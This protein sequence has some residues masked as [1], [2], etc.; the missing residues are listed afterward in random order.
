VPI[1]FVLFASLFCEN[2]SF[3]LGADL[4]PLSS[5]S[6]LSAPRN[7]HW[8]FRTIQKPPLPSVSNRSWPKSPLDHFV[9]AN[10]EAKGIPPAEPAEKVRW[11]RRV[12]FD[13]VGL[14]PTPSD[15]DDFLRNSDGNAY[16]R[17]ID[18]LLS[19]PQYGERWGR[20]WL[21]L[22]RFAES[23]GF[24]H[25]AVR[26]HAWRY[27]DYV[28]RS[29]NADKPYDTFV[30]EQIAGDTFDQGDRDALIA[31][32]FNLLG[33]DMVDSADQVQRRHNSL[34]DMTDTTGLVFLGLTVGCA[35]C[36]DHKF[37]PISQKDYY[38]LQA[39]FTPSVF[40]RD[41]PIPTEQEQAV[42]ETAMKRHGMR[43]HEMRAKIEVLEKPY[44]EQVL[45]E[46]L[47]VLS[48]ETR[49]AHSAAKDKRTAEQI[50]LVKQT[51][52]NVA[53]SEKEL[54]DRMP[55][56]D[57]SARKALLDS[58]KRLPKPYPVPMTLALKHGGGVGEKTYV[59]S[60]GDYANPT[61]EVASDFPSVLKSAHSRLGSI[62]GSGA[63]AE[64]NDRAALAEWIASDD[65]PLTARVM[66]N[67]IWQH[68][69]G[70]GLVPSSSDFG[71]NGQPPTHPK[72]LDWLAGQFIASGWSIKSMHKMILLSATY[73][74]S[75]KASLAALAG[76]P[77]NRLY[78]RFPRLRLEGEVIRDSLLAISGRLNQEME[79]PG[80]YPPISE[81][82]FKGAKGWQASLDPEDH[83]RRSI[84]IFARRNL[85][86]PFLEVFDA[87]DNNV[88]CAAREHSTS[89]PQSL[90]L[91]NSDEAM[92]A[93]TT[94]AENLSKTT[95]SIDDQIKQAFR[96]ILT[97]L[98][99]AQEMEMSREFMKGSPLRE[100]CRALFNSNAFVYVD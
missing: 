55:K 51:A 89:A 81:H 21:D 43:E 53:I 63:A 97:R 98:P 49:A 10:L 70:R 9:L 64:R 80:V 8:A 95:N 31:T 19:S 12:T 96:L 14:P 56:E 86:F 54:L 92:A 69:F 77:E 24:E 38:S 57:Q 28:V 67:R 16:E 66:V 94:L 32:A 4:S 7:E 22:V 84:Y 35:R 44:R 50:A 87:P 71:T 59:L 83:A 15:L 45:A 42:Y 91:L 20:H 90:T 1:V 75:S 46:K 25:D 74:Q 39:F 18:R 73:R 88:S 29:L 93:A 40:H 100:L 65:N 5:E 82:V 62:S 13:L 79:G 68:H 61:E 76:D 26:P 11:L 99:S 34:N 78:S 72:L 27:R 37:E 58:L 52:K 3:T 23:D 48:E 6:T 41:F 33:P 36:H 60:R 17:I 2:A 85:R 47:A 30:K